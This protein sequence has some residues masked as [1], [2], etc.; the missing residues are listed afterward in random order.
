M[1]LFLHIFK[2]FTNFAIRNEEGVIVPTRFT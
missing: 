2:N 1:P